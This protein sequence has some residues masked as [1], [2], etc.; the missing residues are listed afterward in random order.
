[1]SARLEAPNRRGHICHEADILV[2][3]VT[4]M[5]ER[6]KVEAAVHLDIVVQSLQAC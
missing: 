4:F 3:A 1:M 6:F 2:A 5:P